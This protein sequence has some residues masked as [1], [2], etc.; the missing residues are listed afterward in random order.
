ME[1]TSSSVL[2][3]INKALRANFDAVVH[4]PLPH[5][6]VD[7]IHHLDDLERVEREGDQRDERQQPTQARHRSLSAQ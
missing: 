4:E 6:W 5:R 7:L 3:L 1:R 2:G